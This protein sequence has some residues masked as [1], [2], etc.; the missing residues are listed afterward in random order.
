M[1]AGLTI[2]AGTDTIT[3]QADKI[4]EAIALPDYKLNGDKVFEIM[5][6]QDPLGAINAEELPL[7]KFM[8]GFI[9]T[10]F[11]RQSNAVFSESSL[12]IR[13]HDIETKDMS[14]E[15]KEQISL[16]TYMREDEES[17]HK[18]Y[19][20]RKR[21]YL[22]EYEIPAQVLNSGS[23]QFMKFQHHQVDRNPEPAEVDVRHLFKSQSMWD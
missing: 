14:M 21:K 16:V 5:Q 4:Q 1:L 15:E 18:T 17:G 23:N 8:R 13:G 10:D 19:F 12:D 6:E 2:L 11:N 9:P 20:S 22:D 7:T 3:E